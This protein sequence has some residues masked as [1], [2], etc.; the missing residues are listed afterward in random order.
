MVSYNWLNKCTEPV[1]SELTGF[2]PDSC[3]P[4]ETGVAA[5]KTKFKCDM[6][7]RRMSCQYST[8]VRNVK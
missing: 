7:R 6:R 2:E 5:F 8:A 1:S 3:K 4:Q